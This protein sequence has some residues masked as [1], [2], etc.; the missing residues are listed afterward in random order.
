MN[1]TNWPKSNRRLSQTGWGKWSNNNIHLI[2][3]L[4]LI[5]F[6]KYNQCACK[7]SSNDSTKNKRN[8]YSTYDY[9]LPSALVLRQDPVKAFKNS[10]VISGSHQAC[11][12]SWDYRIHWLLLCGGEDP[13]NECPW[14][15]P[16]QSEGEVPVMVKL[17]GM[18]LYCNRYQV[19]S[20]PE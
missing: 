17:W 2:F 14:Y 15:N 9:D 1:T 18:P 3:I 5:S 7:I 13:L 16:K 20:G 19:N 10:K 6:R 4:L 11:P 8:T 12:V